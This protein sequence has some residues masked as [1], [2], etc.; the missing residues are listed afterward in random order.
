MPNYGFENEENARRA[1]AA[2]SQQEEDVRN[3]EKM[4]KVE[5]ASKEAVKFEKKIN[6]HVS[7]VLSQFS[8]AVGGDGKV[9]RS[10]AYYEPNEKSGWNVS[11]MTVS[12]TKYD[13]GDNKRVMHVSLGSPR[14]AEN[15]GSNNVNKLGDALL[16]SEGVD[17]VIIS[18][19]SPGSGVRMMGSSGE[20]AS[21][22]HYKK[23]KDSTDKK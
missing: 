1:R 4:R 23:T 8:K 19:Y 2:Q 11:G 14:D 10:E 12:T 15:Y 21:S 5:E 6:P 20:G 7:D 3:A 18:S 16:Q 13:F 17:E 9:S 22:T